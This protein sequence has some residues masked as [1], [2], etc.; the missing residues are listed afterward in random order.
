MQETTYSAACPSGLIVTVREAQVRDVKQL[1]KAARDSRVDSLA[2]FLSAL[3]VG[4]E[5]PGP[6]T[7]SGQRV[8]STDGKVNWSA[9]L[10]GDSSAMFINA[11]VNAFGT[12]LYFK[13]SCANSLCRKQV[14]RHIEIK[15]IVQHGL[16]DL[17]F[18]T[19]TEHGT[20]HQFELE[21]PR[22]GVVVGW[23]LLTRADQHKVDRIIEDKI[24]EVGPASLLV[25]LPY[26]AGCG[27]PGERSK[28]VNHLVVS[29][30]DF[31]RESYEEHDILLEDMVEV[32]CSRCGHI[33]E[34]P[35]PT[36]K[37]FF[38]SRSAA[39]PRPS[40]NGRSKRSTNSDTSQFLEEDTGTSEAR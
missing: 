40:K 24:D 12:D 28:F 4:V 1:G 20:D 33:F 2:E 18:K 17:A 23:K 30:S 26:I 6:Y 9:A 35:L 11:R 19:V 10:Q 13:V 37:D 27:T 16:S 22:C 3:T 15:D 38:S 29:D 5:D 14:E 32:T 34:T 31:L 7:W 39:P 36:G 8:I 25:R 21:L